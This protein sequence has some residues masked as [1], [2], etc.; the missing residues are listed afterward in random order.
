M[1]DKEEYRLVAMELFPWTLQ[2]VSDTITNKLKRF[3]AEHITFVR[4]A[5]KAILTALEEL[6]GL[7]Y[8]HRDLKLDNFMVSQKCKKCFTQ[9][10]SSSTTSNW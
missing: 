6:H 8:V 1:V 4:F 9:S 3:D 10:I 7:G 2:T 5:F